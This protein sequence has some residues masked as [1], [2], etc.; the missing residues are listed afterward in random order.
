MPI[1]GAP[2][3]KPQRK[4]SER[5]AVVATRRLLAGVEVS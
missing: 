2:K 4:I 5:L 1:G 3:S